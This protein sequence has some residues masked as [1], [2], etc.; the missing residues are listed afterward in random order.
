MDKKP[1]RVHLSSPQRQGKVEQ[2]EHLILQPNHHENQEAPW[3]KT[4]RAEHTG[5]P[6]TVT[7]TRSWGSHLDGLATPLLLLGSTYA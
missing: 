7:G 1:P 3:E 6:A 2:R 5:P 4:G